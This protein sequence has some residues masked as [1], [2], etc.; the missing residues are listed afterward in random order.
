MLS[1]AGLSAGAGIP[2]YRDADGKWQRSN[3]IQ[4]QDFVNKP[5]ARQRYWLRSYAGWPAVAAATPS[6]AHYA[7]KNLEQQALV[8]LTVT[9]NVDRLHQRA[10]SR[11]VIDLHGRLDQVVCLNCADITGRDDMQRRLADLNPTLGKMAEKG[12]FGLAPDGDADVTDDM[13][14]RLKIPACE[15]CEGTLK[16]NVVFFGD[17][18]PRATVQSIYSE[19]DGADGLM[20]VG[21]S[22]QVFSGFR[23]CRYAADRGLHIASVNPGRTRGDE[24]VTHRIAADADEALATYSGT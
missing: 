4:H 2:T 15:Q 20:I 12:D 5:Q 6:P 14:H 21:S 16:P 23:F 11:E 7:I 13:V 9:Q 18:V 19:L 22:L 3:P 10:G 17:N 1:G 24:L 8:K